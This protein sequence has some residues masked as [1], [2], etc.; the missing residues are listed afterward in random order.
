MNK[1]T[2]FYIFGNPLLEFDNLPIKLIP[3]LQK[4]FPNINF[5]EIDP[6]ENLKPIDGKLNLIDTVFGVE[7]VMLIDDI[8][9]IDK[10]ES[11]PN[12]SMHDFDLGFNLKLLKKI[13]LLK[14]INIIAVPT[15]IEKK[16]A[17]EKIKNI[18]DKI[19]T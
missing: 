8:G 18:M 16:K 7:E 6:N 4:S 3:D 1:K 9:T 19:V 12:V 5:I 11:N 10:I 2:T 13:D 17:L 14:D 15:N